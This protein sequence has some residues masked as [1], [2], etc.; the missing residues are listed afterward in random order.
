MFVETTNLSSYENNNFEIIKIDVEGSEI[1]VLKAISFHLENCSFLF[2]EIMYKN[3]IE[4]FELLKKY[5]L[6]SIV[7]S[8][9][10]VGNFVFKKQHI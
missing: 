2:I 4:I 8:D 3:R 7:E 9:D 1:D 10:D 5:N 6:H